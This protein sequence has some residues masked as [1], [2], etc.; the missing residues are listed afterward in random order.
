MVASEIRSASVWILT[1]L[2]VE[3]KSRIQ[4]SKLHPCYYLEIL[5]QFR[6]IVLLS[7]LADP[8]IT[9]WPGNSLVRTSHIW[10]AWGQGSGSL[11]YRHRYR[12][13]ISVKA[14][15]GRSLA[16]VWYVWHLSY[17]YYSTIEGGDLSSE[18]LIA[19]GRDGETVNA[20]HKCW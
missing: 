4:R 10:K 6:P 20:P 15:I 11:R 19:R 7:V 2:L 18:S 12:H 16:H 3:L 8:R 1:L 14:R 5:F 13:R 17:I 9:L